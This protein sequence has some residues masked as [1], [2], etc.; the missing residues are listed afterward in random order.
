MFTVPFRIVHLLCV[1][2]NEQVS[3]MGR[4]RQAFGR[5]KCELVVAWYK[6]FVFV[7]D[8]HAWWHCW[9][10]SQNRTAVSMC[11]ALLCRAAHRFQG[12]CCHRLRICI[13]RTKN[14]TETNCLIACDVSLHSFTYHKLLEFVSSLRSV[15]CFFPPSCERT[16]VFACHYID[17]VVI[18]L[19]FAQ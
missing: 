6:W 11:P 14:E 8:K 19:S 18:A 13:V 9:N 3:K 1:I 17:M 10:F 16:Y 2:A 7:G 4:R 5:W 15:Q 12:C